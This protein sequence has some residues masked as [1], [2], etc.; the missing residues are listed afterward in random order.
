MGRSITK[1]GRAAGSSPSY[2]WEI[3]RDVA[4]LAAALYLLFRPTSRFALDN[5]LI[6]EEDDDGDD[7]EEADQGSAVRSSG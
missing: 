3:A 7:E 6:P 5:V 1:H 4:L 2:G